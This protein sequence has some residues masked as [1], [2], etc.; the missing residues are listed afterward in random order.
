MNMK[1]ERVH[2]KYTFCLPGVK[3][4]QQIQSIPILL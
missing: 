2:A 3:K 1:F 4:T